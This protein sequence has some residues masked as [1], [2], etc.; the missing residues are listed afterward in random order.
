MQIL[1]PQIDVSDAASTHSRRAERL[2]SPHLVQLDTRAFKGKPAEGTSST[3]RIYWQVLFAFLISVMLVAKWVYLPGIY[4]DKKAGITAQASTSFALP[5]AL[6][7]S[8]VALRK[9]SV[10]G[11]KIALVA[12]HIINRSENKL[13]IPQLN[14]V[15]RQKDGQNVISWRYRP[16]QAFLKAGASLRFTSKFNTDVKDG[17]VVEIQFVS[18]NDR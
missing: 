16:Q 6:E 4:S 8:D 1:L 12:G 7:V 5:T 9:I 15:L 14:I 18:G 10:N 17:S 2:L 3:I 13:P 11:K